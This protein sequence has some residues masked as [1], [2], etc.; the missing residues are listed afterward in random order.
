MAGTDSRLS[1]YD[2]LLADS[3]AR[4]VLR[5]KYSGNWVAWAESLDRVVAHGQTWDEI[6]RELRRSSISPEQIIFEWIEP[7]AVA[8]S[9]AR[10]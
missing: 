10:E 6:N 5:E 9:R 4:A 7:M 1:D 3:P 8:P 2:R